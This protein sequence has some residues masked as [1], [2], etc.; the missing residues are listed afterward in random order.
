[1]SGLWFRP[2][3][4]GF[5][6]I[7]VLWVGVAVT[8][9]V[10]FLSRD[11]RQTMRT[12]GALEARMVLHQEM[13]SLREIFR[14][15]LREGRLGTPYRNNLGHC[16]VEVA[17][18]NYFLDLNRASFEEIRRLCLSLKMD[19]HQA[20]IIADSIRDWIDPDMLEQLNGAEDDY[21]LNLRPP[22]RSKNAPLER[23]GELPLVRG[24]DQ[25]ILEKM[26]PFISF[27]GTGIDFRHAPVEVIYAITGDWDIS[28]RIVDYRTEYGLDDEAIPMLLGLHLYR[29]LLTRYT[30]GPSSHYRLTVRGTYKGVEQDVTEWVTKGVGRAG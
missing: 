16:W 5:V 24:I 14:G 4:R 2:G 6:L 19:N 23:Y 26:Q 21:Y 27:E 7:Y 29:A 1:M 13:T 15:V 8:A 28:R 9:L 17:D 10:F 3:N 22:Y 18:A 11:S 25:D 30:F 12:E 20:E